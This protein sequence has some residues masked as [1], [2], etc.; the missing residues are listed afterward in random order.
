MGKR[1]QGF[2]A[3]EL[4]VTMA[5]V[6][7]LLSAGVPAFKNYSWNLRMKTALDSLQTDLNLARR[8]AINLNIQTVTC[9]AQASGTC[10]GN[11][12]WHNGWI[13]FADL[14]TDRQRQ[15]GE[16]LLK[17]S[18]AVEFINISSPASRSYVRF[19][20]NGS[21]PGSNMTIRFCDGRG[22]EFAGKVSVSNSG[23]IKLQSG[24]IESTEN[25]P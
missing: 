5:I 12:D 4:L 16:P 23:R 1:Q 19:Y 14:N 15:T 20:P 10:S 6:A 11:T 2:T 7:I 25:C 18:S 22:S 21:A 3:L 13:V 24:G 8:Q 17:H 9:P